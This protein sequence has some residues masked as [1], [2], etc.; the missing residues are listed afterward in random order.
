MNLQKIIDLMESIAPKE[1]AEEWDNVGLMID[2]ENKEISTVVTALDFNQEVLDFAIN[3]KADMIITHHP[4]IFSSLKNITDPLYIKAIKNDIC[5]FSAHTN[6]DSAAKGVNYVLANSLG[7]REVCSDEMMRYGRIDECSA[8][9][10]FEQVKAALGV[11]ALR[12][13][14]YTHGRIS[15]VAV[16]G[17][18]GGDFVK[19]AAE[20]GCHAYVTGDASYHHAQLAERLGITLICAGHYETE[21]PIAEQLKNLLVERT[22][23]NVLAFCEKNVFKIC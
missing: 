14:G 7:L 20:L 10:F 2:R 5:V 13:S 21:N 12:V 16:L 11:K 8:S 22:D 4:A 1:L 3:N 17:G 19:K 6:L 23:L 9:E 15:R 18:S